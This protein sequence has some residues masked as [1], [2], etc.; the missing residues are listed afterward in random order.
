MTAP[1]FIEIDGWVADLGCAGKV[2]R[3]GDQV[4]RVRRLVV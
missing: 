4:M 2:K 3:V 1:R